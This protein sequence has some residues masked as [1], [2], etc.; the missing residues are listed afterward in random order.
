MAW[1]A[2]RRRSAGWTGAGPR[3]PRDAGSDPATA[4]CILRV[5]C[6]HAGSV[7]RLLGGSSARRRA[8]LGR[9]PGGFE[10][11]NPRRACACTAPACALSA[12][13]TRSAARA[14]PA[15]DRQA[16][17]PKILQREKQARADHA[18]QQARRPTSGQG[19]A[20]WR[21]RRHGRIADRARIRRGRRIG[22][23]GRRRTSG[24]GSI[25][26]LRVDAAPPSRSQPLP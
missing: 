20:G 25:G 26:R 19:D 10:R 17:R 2:P 23:P 7:E 1:R 15:A 24:S 22:S 11:L 21:E 3:R 16:R 9:G 13:G 4:A 14:R 18:A 12:A 6:R 8:L 5:G